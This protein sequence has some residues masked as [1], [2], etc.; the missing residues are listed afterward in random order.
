MNTWII[1]TDTIE[2]FEVSCGTADLTTFCNVLIGPE[3]IEVCLFTEIG[4]CSSV[5]CEVIDLPD[6][7]PIIDIETQ[8][9]DQT[10]FLDSDDCEISDY[11]PDFFLFSECNSDILLDVAVTTLEGS[12]PPETL[13]VGSS[14][15]RLKAT[16]RFGLSDS[17]VFDITVI[18]TTTPELTIDIVNLYVDEQGQAEFN[19]EQLLTSVDDNCSELFIIGQSL[20]TLNCEDLGERVIDVT[21][22]DQFERSFSYE[23]PL[24]LRDTI[25]STCSS[26]DILVTLDMDSDSTVTVQYNI[27]ADDNCG[28]VTITTSRSAETPFDCN[29]TTIVDVLVEDSSGNTSTC[30]FEVTIGSCPIPVDLPCDPDNEIPICHL[31]T[32][33]LY[34]SDAADE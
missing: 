1:G 2:R 14:S 15:F 30:S 3:P 12:D 19:L 5:F 22:G 34:T 8:S 31:D 32:C 33:L 17:I 20:V 10:I 13:T 6:N 4:E 11:L 25:S 24:L 29:T 9:F 28:D 18:D 16:D 7:P 27:M 21:L 23:I 26:E